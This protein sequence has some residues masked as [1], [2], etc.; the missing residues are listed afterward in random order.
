MIVIDHV[1]YGD[2][3]SLAEGRRDHGLCIFC[4][5]GCVLCVF[6][7]RAISFESA[8]PLIKF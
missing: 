8:S 3:T 1:I 5:F 6:A 7:V 4:V 2:L